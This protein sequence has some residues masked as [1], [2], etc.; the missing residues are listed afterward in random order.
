MMDLAADDRASPEVRADAI[1]ALSD[2]RARLAT[3]GSGDSA[4]RAHRLL[5]RRDLAEFLDRPETR[6]ARRPAPE[7]PPGRPIG[8]EPSR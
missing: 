6:S 5:A 8:A 2:L 4:G 3:G 7:P 1:A